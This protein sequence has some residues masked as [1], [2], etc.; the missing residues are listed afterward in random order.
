VLSDPELNERNEK[1]KDS[2]ARKQ[3][4]EVLHLTAVRSFEQLNHC[5]VL[6][7]LQDSQHRLVQLDLVQVRDCQE[8]GPIPFEVHALRTTVWSTTVEDVVDDHF[9]RPRLLTVNVL[10]VQK[11]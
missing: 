3:V 9:N 7:A 4:G 2:C 5:A 8:P 11:H 1:R 6:V 10:R